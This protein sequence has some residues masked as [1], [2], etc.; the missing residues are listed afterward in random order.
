MA[1]GIGAGVAINTVTA[2]TSASIG[3]AHHEA[4]SVEVQAIAHKE[5]D[6]AQSSDFIAEAVSGAAG[7][8]VGLAG[9]FALNS[10]TSNA[11]AEIKDGA[12]I[13]VHQDAVNTG[14]V[15]IEAENR[16]TSKASATPQ[17]KGGTGGSLGLG[18]SIAMNIETNKAIAELNG[19]ITGADDVTL[20]ALGNHV[21][22]TTAEAGAAGGIAITPVVGL[23]VVDN[24]AT[25]SIN[26]IGNGN[27][28]K[29][30][31]DINVSASNTGDTI[32]IAKGAA[33][34]G[35][36]AVG[37]AIAVNVI[38]DAAN[39]MTARN[40]NAG[41]NVTFDAKASGS[42]A[43]D[44]TASAAGGKADTGSKATPADSQEQGGVDKSI[45]EQTS[46]GQ[47]QQGKTDGE[48]KK[49]GSASTSEGKLAVAAAVGVNVADT[50]AE[51]YT[52]DGR[53]INAGGKLTVAAAHF[54]DDSAKADGAAVGTASVGIGA[55]VAINTVDASSSATIGIA[56]HHVKGAEVRAEALDDKTS[57][58]SA[59]AM[60]GAGAGKVGIAGSFALNSVDNTAE[61]QIKT[62][63]KVNAHEGD[64]AIFAET[65]T[66]HSARAVPTEG[67][68]TTG[69]SKLGVGASVALNL[70]DESTIATIAQNAQVLDAGK[71]SIHAVSA[72]D[73][74][75]KANAGA[76]G[77]IA[78]DAVVAMTE[79]NQT[80][81]ATIAQNAMVTTH[82]DTSI[83]AQTSGKNEAIA[84]GDTKSEKVGVGA[85]A[86]VILSNSGASVPLVAAVIDGE[87]TSGGGLELI[88]KADRSYSASSTASA[89]GALN[90]EDV[91]PSN[92]SAKTLQDNQ[93]SQK[94]TPGG[95]K[96]KVAAALG[97][98]YTNDDVEAVITD[99]RNIS[100]NGALTVA[101]ENKSDVKAVGS[102]EA[103]DPLTA[104]G[105]GVGVAMTINRSE[106]TATIG[107]GVIIEKAGDLTVSAVS[108]QNANAEA[109]AGAGAKSIGVAG[110]LAVTDSEV[111]TKAAVSQDVF[112]KDAGSTA[113]T[114]ANTSVLAAKAWSVAVAGKVGVGAAIGVV[115]A[116][117][118]VN[119]AIGN[120]VTLDASGDLAVTSD[121]HVISNAEAITVGAGG[122][123]GG[124][125]A[126][127]V[128]IIST[129]TDAHIATGSHINAD[130]TTS[131]EADASE[132]ATTRAAGAGAGGT[133][134]VAASGA[135]TVLNTDTKAY[136]DHNVNINQADALGS[137]A[138][139]SVNVKAEDHTSVVGTG[140]AGAVGGTAGIG[141]G[142]DIGVIN[143]DTTAFIGHDTKVNAGNSVSVEAIAS[144]EVRSIAASG[145]GGGT[146]GIAGAAS[147][148]TINNATAAFI[149]TMADVKADGNVKVAAKDDTEANLIG[150][151][152]AFGGTAGVGASAG[153][154]VINKDTKAYI[155]NNASVTALG[156]QAAMNAETGEYQESFHN[157][158]TKDVQDGKV[159]MPGVEEDDQYWSQLD[160][161]NLLTKIRTTTAETTAIKGIAV[162]ATSKNDIKASV[163]AGAGGGTAG[164]AGS[165]AVTIIDNETQAFIGD[166]TKINNDNAQAGA[167]QSVMVA[168]GTDYYHLGIAGSVAA[169]G[170]VGVGPGAQV[171]VTTLHTDAHIGKSTEVKAAEDVKVTAK[172]EENMLTVVAAA[173]GGGMVGVA[174]AFDVTIMNSDT[175]AYIDQAA[176]VSADNNVLVAASDKTSSAA[177]SGSAGLG[178]GAAGVGGSLQV[179]V[180]NKDTTAY[181]AQGATVDGKANGTSDLTVYKDQ[182]NGSRTTDDSFQGVAV[183]ADSSE[184]LVDVVASGAAGLYAG[185]AGAVSVNTV[186]SHTD[187]HI[188]ESANVNTDQANVGSDQSVNV[189]AVNDL[190]IFSVGGSVAGGLVGVSGGVDVGVISNNTTA[191]IGNGANVKAAD[192][193]A[194]NALAT[195]EIDSFAVSASTGVVGVAGGVSVYSIGSGLSADAKNSLNSNNGGNAQGYADEQL[196]KNHV[197]TLFQGY[198][199]SNA[200]GVS[201]ALA[202]QTK[203]FSVTKNVE[204]TTVP[205][206]TS[207]FIGDNATISAG[208][209]VTINAKDMVDYRV[210]N[211]GGA[212]GVTHGV[213]G[214]VG[215]LTLDANTD[216]HIGKNVILSS[217]GTVAVKAGTKHNL[218]SDAYASAGGLL[219]ALGAAANYVNDDTNTTAYIGEN[220]QLTVN[221]LTVGADASTTTD[222]KA[223]NA[224]IGGVAL[225][226]SVSITNL[227][228]NTTAFI[229]SGAAIDATGDI[230]VRATD[231]DNA[232]AAAEGGAAGYLGGLGASV[233]LVND[234]GNTTAFIGDNSQIKSANSIGITAVS[235]DSGMEA[236]AVGVGVGLVGA[237]A[238]VAVSDVD[239]TTSAYTG[240]NVQIGET[241]K[242]VGAI[243]ISAS[244]DSDATAYTLAGAAGIGAG[245]GSV[246]TANVDN[247]VNAVLGT[248]NQVVNTGNIA[249]TALG[250][251]KADAKASGYDVGALAVGA[252]VAKANVDS[253]INAQV[254]SSVLLSAGNV[255]VAA[256]HEVPAGEY[257]AKSDSVAAG[258]GLI[259]IKATDSSAKT[260]SDVNASIETGTRIY[261]GQGVTV[262]AVND[263]RQSA[264]VSGIVGGLIAAGSNNADATS[265]TSTTAIIGDV[266]FTGGDVK[267]HA[268]G[269]DDN[270][271]EATAG[272]GG[273]A[274]GAAADAGTHAYNR[275]LAQIG[276]G[277]TG[278]AIAATNLKM[279]AEHLTKFNSKSD[280]M[281]AAAVGFS[282]AFA[283]NDVD[284]AVEAKVADNTV[285]VTTGKTGIDIASVNKVQ[286]DYIGDN[287]KGGAGGVFNGSSVESNSSIAQD[288]SVTIGE[289][290]SLAALGMP[291]Y[292]QPVVTLEA[293]NEITTSDEVVLTTGG[294]AQ[295]PFA[296]SNTTANLDADVTVGA[297]AKIVSI[298]GI[299]I[300]TYGNNRIVNTALVKTYGGVGFAGGS[301]NSVLDSTQEVNIN[302]NAYLL[303]YGNINIAAGAGRS[304]DSNMS[305]IAVTDVYN[306]T[307]LPLHTTHS[308]YA[309]LK[310]SNNLNIANGAAISGLQDVKLA[311][312]DGGILVKAS[313][314]GHN[315]YLDALAFL[316]ISKSE[317][318]G[319]TKTVSTGTLNQNGVVKAGIENEKTVNIDRNGNITFGQT[320]DQA[321]LV[322]SLEQQIDKLK[323]AFDKAPTSIEKLELVSRIAVLEKMKKQDISGQEATYNPANDLAN[324]IN[325]LKQALASATTAAEKEDIQAQ[326]DTFEILKSAIANKDVDMIKV[327][328]IMTAG[329][330]VTLAADAIN[331]TGTV[332]AYGAPKINITNASNKYLQVNGLTIAN[333]DPGGAVSFTGS[334]GKGALTVQ[335]IGKNGTPEINIRNTYDT[336]S[337]GPAI[338]LTGN[339]TN[340]RGDVNI[341]NQSGA[342]AQFSDVRA[343]AIG[344]EVPNSTFVVNNPGFYFAG[345]APEG[346]LN[347]LNILPG[348][349]KK[350]IDLITN[351]YYKDEFNNWVKSNPKIVENGE[352]EFTDFT[353]SYFLADSLDKQREKHI[354]KP[355]HDFWASVSGGITYAVGQFPNKP[356]DWE[357]PGGVL[358][359]VVFYGHGFYGTTLTPSYQGNL[360]SYLTKTA[361][362]DESAV[363]SQI[364]NK[365]T[366]AGGSIAINAKYIDVNGTIKSG[367]ARDFSVKINENL[368]GWI[369]QQTAL[370]VTGEVEIPKAYWSVIDSGDRNP[371]MTYNFSTNQIQVDDMNVTN[372]YVSLRGHILS[373]NTLGNIEVMTGYGDVD[374]VNKSSKALAIRNIDTSSN[375]IAQVKIADTA[376][377]QPSGNA[378]TTWYVYDMKQGGVSIYESTTGASDY[379]GA[380]LKYFTS[381]NGA[382][383][384]NPVANQRYQWT[385][386]AELSRTWDSSAYYL[387]E[388]AQPTEWKWSIPAGNGANDPWTYTS[389][390]VMGSASDPYYTQTI[391][392]DT[393]KFGNSMQTKT[394]HFRDGDWLLGM[395]DS[396]DWTVVVP[397][398]AK[399]TAVS[400]VKAD[401]PFKIQFHSGDGTIKTTSSVNID[402]AAGI[403]IDGQVKNVVGDVSL[404]ATGKN[405]GISQTA[406]AAVV[407]NN[408]NISADNNIGSSAQALAVDLKGS[409]TAVSG[410]GSIYIDAPQTSLTIAKAHGAGDIVLT[411]AGDLHSVKL[412]ANA[413][414][415][416]AVKGANVDLVSLTGAI[417]SEENNFTFEAV[418][419]SDSNGKVTNGTINAHARGDIS[420]QQTNGDMRIDEI[421]SEEGNIHVTANNG[422][423]VSAVPHGMVDA[424]QA[425]VNQDRLAEFD[426][427]QDTVKPYQYNVE[428]NYREYWQLLQH[429]KVVNGSFVLNS[430]AI[431]DFK[432][433]AAANLGIDNPTDAQVRAYAGS[434]Y[435]DVTNV[436]TDAMGSKWAERTE[437]KQYNENYTFVI[438]G[439]PT[440]GRSSLRAAAPTASTG[441]R[442]YQ[443]LIEGA[444]WTPKYEFNNTPAVYA[445][446]IDAG[447]GK[448]VTFSGTNT[449]NGMPSQTIT[450]IP[451]TPEEKAKVLTVADQ[452]PEDFHIEGDKLVIKQ[453]TPVFVSS[454]DIVNVDY[455]SSISLA[456]WED[457]KIGHL[458]SPGNIK[459]SAN[460]DILNVSTDPVAIT[461]GTNLE[462]NAGRNIGTAEKALTIGTTGT[463]KAQAK[464]NIYLSRPTGDINYTSITAGNIVSLQADAGSIMH[465]GIGGGII[466]DKLITKS[467]SEQLLTGDNTIQEFTAANETGDIVLVNTADTL[468]VLG[469][470]QGNGGTVLTN[471]GAIQMTGKTIAD[472]LDVTSQSGSIEVTD[473]SIKNSAVF[474]AD[475][476]TINNLSH[477]GENPLHI[478]ATGQDNEMADTI[479]MNLQSDTG[480]VFDKLT[481]DKIRINGQ[482]DELSFYN[483]TVGSRA[484]FN[485]SHA[486][487]IAD[488]LHKKLFGDASL[489]IY[490]Q[491]KPFYLLMGKD[492]KM[493]TNAFI[494]NYDNDF[495]VNAFDT[496]N[497][498]IRVSE[499]LS[500]RFIQGPA[501]ARSNNP[502]ENIAKRGTP[503]I[504]PE[505]HSVSTNSNI[506]FHK[507]SV[508]NVDITGMPEE[509]S[510]IDKEITAQPDILEGERTEDKRDTE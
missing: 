325:T 41:G 165:G 342:V 233:A 232:H 496:E 258:G 3:A 439:T 228:G 323:L 155:A 248:G 398:E 426:A 80:T 82:D 127:A 34:G 204:A 460:R 207:A 39:A 374:V 413:A 418:S 219:N 139:Q 318:D 48:K 89:K 351:V 163:A 443:E 20:K 483:T 502:L 133:A 480:I 192:S 348:T 429:G 376:K 62:G 196:K 388:A 168:A 59:E 183:Q 60:S 257:T 225:G 199:D 452:L 503:T 314:T 22:R 408:L 474:T 420:L 322:N 271:A 506:I 226:A 44:A 473:A 61:A 231:E 354:D 12:T 209:D 364:G 411:A 304:G 321:N 504:Y 463:V 312:E 450:E 111:N 159:I 384:Y 119:A 507:D 281:N 197:S 162:T 469:I 287:A 65:L 170:T 49:A 486:T 145:A 33:D 88:A 193:I 126:V 259:G 246:A 74:L 43:A 194:V 161:L 430:D 260:N 73:T 21:I 125:A 141:A 356:A 269:T 462:L 264:D 272:S 379:T 37:L 190:E 137:N 117:H 164:I 230:T 55:A 52:M 90:K 263:T 187:A 346:F 347:Y 67:G 92:A 97:T 54:A 343:K 132:T 247:K 216:A 298:G 488:N 437:F 244:G 140:G 95:G 185:V 458:S 25:A 8:K 475:T 293:A 410:K 255:T 423:I 222:S 215:V 9:S 149:G 353:W 442:T 1:I 179:T 404:T 29:V 265:N 421:K 307:A 167:D 371:T 58:F 131:V 16:T 477:T 223:I 229:G 427:V 361:G 46:F 101:A 447:E 30:T 370:G 316:G 366:I 341:F 501:V 406:D 121:N 378:L 456:S 284:T 289:N 130:G 498:F 308:A 178:F 396:G 13:D 188:A 369:A 35:K 436:F 313:G 412:S 490:P 234:T 147:V 285:I 362:Y 382:Q 451:L 274:A 340:L 393:N 221:H 53:T 113:V 315:P 339:V 499:K 224:S 27:L 177:I 471:S 273:L 83:S 344:I 71:L 79:L 81:Q 252:S 156:N 45:E 254:N 173:A 250:K 198:S 385:Q 381:G 100:A 482:T 189:S 108:V 335:E 508:V 419:T 205:G 123:V 85:S 94:G 7:G 470:T 19:D 392:V 138:A 40:I 310:N 505:S 87:V 299:D 14:S 28:L 500:N 203:D 428:R 175:S 169:G 146:A 479:S 497:S 363:K 154:A 359:T 319:K 277:A 72:S 327:D 297:N 278:N 78:I 305:V 331:G 23:S 441:G 180:I 136:I 472:S 334:A 357:E 124:A 290:A 135:T 330:N 349:E 414:A 435:K 56:E 256:T 459:L 184:E 115:A 213:G 328:P 317:S 302:K 66:S 495:I 266:N 440:T 240:N 186:T 386:T 212:L 446:N 102:G 235:V 152:G 201:T 214:A 76:A 422:Q 383:W 18:A 489:Q 239:S 6:I 249:V 464:N 415:T 494:V 110:A 309:E 282:G 171:A 118:N 391:D 300:T 368:D 251:E 106:T 50:K 26:E 453:A 211:G 105:I 449:G 116:D 122:K 182:A 465:K 151:S 200:S 220:G 509:T 69:G 355:G 390:I 103:V 109:V 31:G 99:G 195:K 320:K 294:V 416:P 373:T 358:S 242:Y 150:G 407:T 114:A 466:A 77:G 493:S 283:H 84:A 143:K 434:Y 210:M 38:N 280:S 448:K 279:K 15:T 345:G 377:L 218:E 134:G 329:G 445:P 93:S 144:E 172:A 51:A 484:D 454:D 245:S 202:N 98:V 444:D 424:E 158:L 270:Y 326:I 262:E 438:T 267:I 10:V 400:S 409:L 476:I 17:G 166:N 433:R 296:E 457:L 75:T 401:N 301:T 395:P 360:N 402:S 372:G 63:A 261:A 4:G 112:I 468:N 191:Y 380:T 292:D 295:K 467:A 425:E 243:Q 5:G 57:L 129:Q 367:M 303:G 120:N 176:K 91:N 332:T 375:N 311:A 174:G 455:E 397:T 291:W 153:A 68:G 478:T 64:I 431:T 394:F 32:T 208:K 36:A 241:G 333:Q 104:T 24:I 11:T 142:A 96:V 160:D 47:S 42:A 237:G 352:G 2:T 275:T 492:N 324:Q 491:H 405:M 387:T 417:G 253:T 432:D 306:Y 70:V 350:A 510:T 148:Y 461:G 487:V 485:N 128:N 227:N 337:N 389:G 399:L 365:A 217:G 206:G 236:R 403:V 107:D 238:A 268:D 336:S 181:I 276:K 86:A 338:F 481:G 157:P 288:S 286:Q